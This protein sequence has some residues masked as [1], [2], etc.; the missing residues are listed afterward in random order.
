MILGVTLVALAIVFKM[1]IFGK[2][3]LHVVKKEDYVVPQAQDTGTGKGG[4]IG[5]VGVGAVKSSEYVQRDEQKRIQRV[6]G[7]E[8]LLHQ[9]GDNW[10]LSKPYMK[11][12]EEGGDVIITADTGNVQVQTIG[13][14]PVPRDAKLTGNVRF[15]IV[16]RVAGSE[17][18]SDV[19]LD[20]MVFVSDR[21]TF[22]TDG[23]VKLVSP[24]CRMQGRGLE[25]VYSDEMKS[26]LLFRMDQL[27]DMRFKMRA[28]DSFL[29]QGGP[30]KT[31]STD[32]PMT[33]A[34]AAE[35]QKQLY[36]CLLSD[37]VMLEYDQQVVLADKILVKNILWTP[38]GSAGA[39]EDAAGGKASGS[40][41]TDT[42]PTVDV[43]LTCEGGVV[44]KPLTGSVEEFRVRG[45]SQ[46]QNRLDIL[47]PEQLAQR[48]VF[49]AKRID[50]DM[51]S[52]DGVAQGPVE[53][54]FFAQSM[55]DP[56]VSSGKTRASIKAA[57]QATFA[58][59]DNEIRFIGDVVTQVVEPSAGW[60]QKSTVN[61]D[62]VVA[63][64]RSLTKGQKAGLSSI[65]DL[66]CIGEVVKLESV[67]KSGEK[68]LGG[69][70]L[71][72]LNLHYDGASRV[73]TAAG[74]GVI[75]VDNSHVPAD[76]SGPN[77]VSLSRR[78]YAAVD[79]F[80]E[81]K[82][83]VDDGRIQAEGPPEGLRVAYWPVLADGKYGSRI[84]VDTRSVEG[85]FARLPDGRTEIDAL[86][87]LG[88]VYIE[89]GDSQK[90]WGDKF[91]YK[92]NTGLLTVTGRPDKPC[93][94]NGVQAEQFEMNIRDGS[95]KTN[96]SG[97]GVSR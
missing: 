75:A 27:D 80:G 40:K 83:S 44:I 10:Q 73:V 82:W 92:Q 21:S 39:G 32:Q 29:R 76:A 66:K 48:N 42:A 91:L 17:E 61:S 84:V 67:R 96:L 26:L 22:Y 51:A 43:R 8:E 19:Y 30:Q 64:I 1:F 68:L 69:V 23:P 89:R 65:E 12:Y 93:V 70:N 35:P 45:A 34:A 13:N 56:N 54:V 59:E 37:N 47:S 5:G 55:G 33:A 11:I 85:T 38:A 62:E 16:R 94:Y 4:K 9:T 2:D 41:P 71:K 72:C 3:P 36:E 24:Q 6:F 58:A 46:K 52:G 25:V 78:C 50:Y 7:F 28:G 18:I 88:G 15:H 60:Q 81:L 53:A 49:R 79:K 97:G 87:A 74:P 20:E 86:S 14:S 77:D 95:V 63:R 57:K 90:I 31:G